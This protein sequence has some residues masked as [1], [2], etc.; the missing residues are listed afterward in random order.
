M[1]KRIIRVAVVLLVIIFSVTGYKIYAQTTGE[2]EI[3]EH[4]ETAQ[5]QLS[6]DISDGRS[7]HFSVVKENNEEIGSVELYKINYTEDGV[8]LE[9]TEDES[10][11]FIKIEKATNTMYNVTALNDEWMELGMN[12]FTFTTK[13]LVDSKVEDGVQ[14]DYYLE[15]T[16]KALTRYGRTN[17]E[18]IE[19]KEVNITIPSPIPGTETTIQEDSRYPGE[20]DW[21]T[22]T[23][24][25]EIIVDKDAPYTPYEEY[26]DDSDETYTYWIIGYD[27]ESYW[28]PFIGTFENGKSYIAEFSVFSKPGYKFTEDTIITVN[29]Q[30]VEHVFEKRQKELWLGQSIKCGTD[31][32]ED[33]K[34]YEED[35][36][37]TEIE[38]ET[39]EEKTIENPVT[40][41]NIYISFAI[42]CIAIIILA[43]KTLNKTEEN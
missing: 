42:F 19:I 21:M 5:R 14:H 6:I 15:T 36:S 12:V 25:P 29:G 11:A 4:V 20:Y 9:I 43:S 22:Q 17:P 26:F 27:A 34:E 37:N 32:K 10:L 38:E 31:E 23:N 33:E 1:K 35:K 13:K 7:G 16:Y 8:F 30:E 2:N 24:K 28:K 39:V 41:D 3:V 18:L 40:G